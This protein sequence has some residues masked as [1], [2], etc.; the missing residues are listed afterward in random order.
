M[1]RTIRLIE[2]LNTEIDIAIKDANQKLREI[3]TSQELLNLVDG[4]FSNKFGLGFPLYLVGRSKWCLHSGK[5]IDEYIVR[6]LMSDGI[7]ARNV[8]ARTA[9]KYYKFS[10][11]CR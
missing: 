9:Y 8:D 6:F 2:D 7:S 10:N 1:K 5:I 11:V 3:K 4:Y